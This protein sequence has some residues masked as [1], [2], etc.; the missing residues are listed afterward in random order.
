MV[1]AGEKCASCDGKPKT[2]PAGFAH[3][4]MAC[5]QKRQSC[6]LGKTRCFCTHPIGRGRSPPVSSSAFRRSW[7]IFPLSIPLLAAP[8]TGFPL[9][10][11]VLLK[12][13]PYKTGSSLRLPVFAI[14]RLIGKCVPMLSNHETSG[15]TY[16]AQKKRPVLLGRSFDIFALESGHK[17]V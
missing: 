12:H 5:V 1:C 11:I 2:K 16:L 15:L 17:N 8:K 6:C 3:R 10:S 13:V 4:P 14:Q 7:H 9:H